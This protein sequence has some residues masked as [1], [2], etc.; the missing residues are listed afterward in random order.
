MKIQLSDHFTYS[1]LIRFTIPSIAMMIFTSIY[2]VVDGFFVSNYVGNTP[3]AA[4]NLIMPYIM[5]MSAIGFMLGTGGSAL[6][7]Y[8]LGTGDNKRANGIFSL[9]IYLL[10]AIGLVL[11]IVSLIFI[12]PVAI[13]LGATQE[14]LGYC[15]T[16]ALIS[17]IGLVPFMLQNAFQSFMIVAEKPKLGLYITIA[18]GITNMILDWLFMGV[19][20]MGIGSAAAA[21]V[22]GMYVGGI[23]PLIYFIR[24]NSSLLQLGKPIKDIASIGKAALNGSS[25]FM[26]NVSVSLVNMLYNFQLMKFA[27]EYG[28]SAYGIIMYTNFIF[29]GVFFGYSIGVTPIIGYHY[30]TGLKDEL[31]NVFKK[32][33][34]MIAIAA[35]IMFIIAELLARPLA[36]IFAS[37]DEELLSITTHAIQIYSVSFLIMG[38]NIFGSSLFTALNDGL[39]SAL[40]SFFRTLLFQIASVL[41]LPLIFGLDGI[42]YSIICAELLALFVTS[43][44]IIIFRNKYGYIK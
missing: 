33:L 24:P 4:L 20:R 40:I 12:K 8:T 35:A 37:Y 26:T 30:G 21:S 2:G 36:M 13:M 6:V 14:M 38:F 9:I 42:W 11:S 7:A 19:F 29:I 16:Y 23:L 43:G 15:I 34:T 31:R 22:I 44:C 5:I 10:I 41:V 39:I 27:G 17:M 1:K 3:F 25:E 28:V 32:S 18:A